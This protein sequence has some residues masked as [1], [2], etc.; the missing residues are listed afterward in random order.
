MIVKWGCI[1]FTVSLHLVESVILVC[2][3]VVRPHS[4]EA[5]VKSTFCL[6]SVSVTSV[7]SVAG[8]GWWGKK[9]RICVKIVKYFTQ[10][11]WIYCEFLCSHH[12]L[13]VTLC[14]ITE[15]LAFAPHRL[16]LQSNNLEMM[17]RHHYSPI[18]SNSQR[19]QLGHCWLPVWSETGQTCFIFG[20]VLTL[21]TAS[22]KTERGGLCI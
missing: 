11:H 1:H 2:S 7:W 3:C 18:M 14:E 21:D 5:S 4:L 22:T 13:Q 15:T 12:E 6:Y 8:V 20:P 10:R 17:H 19:Q 16:H 9:F